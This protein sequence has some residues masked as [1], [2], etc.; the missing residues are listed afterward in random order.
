[1]STAKLNNLNNKGD[2]VLVR[3]HPNSLKLQLGSTLLLSLTML[4]DNATIDQLLQL[5]DFINRNH[6]ETIALTY[7]NICVVGHLLLSSSENIE[8]LTYPISIEAD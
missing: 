8:P 3:F 4:Y 5:Q 7:K 1:M 6:N 2:F